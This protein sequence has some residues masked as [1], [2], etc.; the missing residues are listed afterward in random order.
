MC[1]SIACRPYAIS[2][3][4]K[5]SVHQD[6]PVSYFSLFLF[7]FIGLEA[8]GN[9]FMMFLDVL[10]KGMRVQIVPGGYVWSVTICWVVG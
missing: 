5:F 6:S 1:P 2:K 7:P 8:G 9:S 4:S 10:R 3:F